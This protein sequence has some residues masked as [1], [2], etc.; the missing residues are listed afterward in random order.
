[1]AFLKI[2]PLDILD[3]L[4]VAFVIYRLFLLMK[5]TRAIQMLLGL[6]VLLL[7]VITA[8]WWQLEG[9]NWIIS[10]LK[11]VW[12]VAFVIVF[13]PELRTA[14]AQLGKNRIIGL[15]LKRESRAIKEVVEACQ[16]L[17]EKGIGALIVFEMN[18]GLKDHIETGTLLEATVSTEL[19]IT[20]FTPRTP[21][22]DG[23]V[24]IRGE[25]IIAAGCILPLTQNPLIPHTMGMRHRAA[26][27][28]TEETDAVC[29]VVS[30]ETRKISLA[31]GGKMNSGLDP[32]SLRQGL[33][34]SLHMIEG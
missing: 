8:Q 9:L 16:E 15:F 31:V 10:S 26:L 27:G 28:I 17:S 4:I 24:V 7:G 32:V 14:L 25:S 18:T 2:R 11:T 22:H 21:L 29:V 13:Q 23:A 12:V 20:I 1:M 33:M 3:I 5:G 34:K 19:L 30:E 6:L